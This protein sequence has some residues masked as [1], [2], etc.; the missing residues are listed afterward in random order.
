MKVP[1]YFFVS[2]LLCLGLGTTSVYAVSLDSFADIK[3][4]M[5]AVSV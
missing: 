2:S 1:F 4:P 3:K 5:D